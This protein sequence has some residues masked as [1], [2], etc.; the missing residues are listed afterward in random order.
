MDRASRSHAVLFRLGAAGEPCRCADVGALHQRDLPG[1]PPCI[2]HRVPL[3]FHDAC[4]AST[5]SWALVNDRCTAAAAANDAG[6]DEL[7][8]FADYMKFHDETRELMERGQW[9]RV[10]IFWCST[11]HGLGW[12]ITAIMGCFAAALLT[13]RAL[14]IAYDTGEY[15][16]DDLDVFFDEPLVNMNQQF[17]LW[18]L[19]RQGMADTWLHPPKLYRLQE[20]DMLCTDITRLPEAPIWLWGWSPPTLWVRLAKR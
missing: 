18:E 10:R 19:Q 4:S 16:P 13:K 20:E 6:T 14:F 3:D 11:A 2:L 7:M 17:M 12:K 15:Y 8:S 5:I 1:L 9:D